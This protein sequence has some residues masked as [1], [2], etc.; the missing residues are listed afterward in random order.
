MGITQPFPP[1][2]CSQMLISQEN[3]NPLLPLV[4]SPPR[5]SEAAASNVGCWLALLGT[6]ARLIEEGPHT[7]TKLVLIYPRYC[8][9]YSYIPNTSSYIFLRFSVPLFCH[10]IP[11]FFLRFLPFLSFVRQMSIYQLS[12]LMSIPFWY[13]RLIVY[14]PIYLTVEIYRSVNWAE[15]FSQCILV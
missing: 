13:C 12:N 7:T 8:V 11:I 4:L 2:F 9:F 1:E 6:L 10:F 14:Y 3:K 5:K 15:I